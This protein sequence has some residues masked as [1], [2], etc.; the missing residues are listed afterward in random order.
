MARP[1]IQTDARSARLRRKVVDVAGRRLQIANLRGSMQETDLTEPANCRGFG[2]IRH[3]RTDTSPGWPPNPLPIV[4]AQRALGLS[5]EPELRGQVFQIAACNWRCWYCFVDDDLLAANPARSSWLSAD[6]LIDL[7]L[8]EPDHPWV[9][10]LTGGQPDLAPEWTPWMMR[11]ILER[12]LDQTIYLWSDDN[13]STDYL[14]QYL[15]ESDL[16]LVAKYPL[17]GRVGCFKGFDAASF[18][19]NTRADPSMFDRQ[20]EI[21]RRLLDLGIDQYAYV[22]LTCRATAMIRDAVARFMD[23]LQTLDAKLPLRTVPLEVREYAPAKA[24][25]EAEAREALVN[26][27]RAVDAW[28]DE[29]AK[30][31]PSSDRSQRIADTRLEGHSV[32]R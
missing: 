8:A 23:R 29:L 18:A 32:V 20:F 11:A 2:R 9:I 24:R 1:A 19:F 17:Y 3:F 4:P 7:F 21:M 27:R 28:Q 15:E 22:T 6:E 16:E 12:G 13:L 25:R 14:W 10:D 5:E 26:Q 31:F 30:R